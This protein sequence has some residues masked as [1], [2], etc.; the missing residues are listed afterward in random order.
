MRTGQDRE[1]EVLYPVLDTHTQYLYTVEP[2]YVSTEL[3]QMSAVLCKVME[4]LSLNVM[5]YMAVNKGCVS[6]NKLIT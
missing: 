3:L 6:C 1:I 5:L 2:A 4:L